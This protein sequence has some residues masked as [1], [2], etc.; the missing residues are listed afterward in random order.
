MS[1]YERRR[2]VKD[3]VWVSVDSLGYQRDDVDGSVVDADVVVIL[4]DGLP[5]FP[6]ETRFQGAYLSWWGRR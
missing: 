3:P 5:N 6:F 2:A 4:G 1:W